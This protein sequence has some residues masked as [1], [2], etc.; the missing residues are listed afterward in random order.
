MSNLQNK[1]GP[2]GAYP[3]GGCPK[4]ISI[5]LKARGLIH[6]Y[7]IIIGLEAYNLSNKKPPGAAVKSC[8]PD[9]KTGHPEE[10]RVRL[11]ILSAIQ[12]CHLKCEGGLRV[13]AAFLK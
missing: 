4:E 3:E 9:K 13:S 12:F 7:K 11:T 1:S 5:Y 2:K 10:R 6:M 8:P